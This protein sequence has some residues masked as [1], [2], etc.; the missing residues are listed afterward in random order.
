M[1]RAPFSD[2]SIVTFLVRR[3]SGT[4]A[5]KCKGMIC[6]GM[7]FVLL[8]RLLRTVRLVCTTVPVHVVRGDLP[9]AWEA[10]LA[11]L[12]VK[13]L[14]MPCTVPLPSWAAG[15]HTPTFQKIAALCLTQ[16][17][18]VLVLDNDVVLLR[19]ID[20]LLR[21]PTPAFVYTPHARGINSG[22][23]VLRPDRSMFAHARRVLALPRSNGSKGDGGDQEAWPLIFRRFFELPICYNARLST[24]FRHHV[25]FKINHTILP[26]DE[27]RGWRGDLVGDT[28]R[29]GEGVAILHT[30][31]GQGSGLSRWNTTEMIRAESAKTEQFLGLYQDRHR[32]CKLAMRR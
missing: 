20:H 21:S 8:I 30:S 2:T 28:T 1:S 25:V 15:F 14:D 10:Q 12:G 18:K 31:D 19:N 32:A 5:G 22:V 17:R 29:V 3:D 13:T 27:Y 23:A 11:Q 24:R 9:S 26:R 7:Q 6:M 4:G 16:F